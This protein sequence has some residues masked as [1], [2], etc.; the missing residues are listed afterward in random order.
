MLPRMIVGSIVTILI[1]SSLIIG[2][3][4]FLQWVLT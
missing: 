1:G 2:L 3:I 4:F